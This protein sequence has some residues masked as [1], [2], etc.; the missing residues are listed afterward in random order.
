MNDATKRRVDEVIAG[1][2]ADGVRRI[3]R[4]LAEL[5]AAMSEVANKSTLKGSE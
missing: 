3:A 1:L 4:E 2:D 5:R